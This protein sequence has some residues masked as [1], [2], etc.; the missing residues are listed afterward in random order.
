MGFQICRFS[1]Q[2]NQTRWGHISGD[3]PH[4]PNDHL[5][6]Q[7]LET[8]VI[9]TADLIALADRTGE[10]PLSS[11]SSRVKAAQLISPVTTDATIVCQGLNY[12]DHAAESGH[13]ERKENLFFKKASSAICGPYDT[14]VRPQ[15]VELLDYEIEIGVVLRKAIS[16]NTVI[17]ETNCGDYIAGFV[18]ANDVSARDVMFGAGYFQWFKG[19]SYR[20]FCPVGPILYLLK[21][22]EVQPIL[23]SLSIQLKLN[24]DIRQSA[25][26]DTQIYKA[27][28]T[29]DLLGD[30]MDMKPGDL[31]LTGTPGGVIAQGTPAILKILTDNLVNDT[32]R[33]K[34]YVE[35]AS[36][37]AEFLKPGDELELTLTDTFNNISLGGQLSVIIEA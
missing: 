19:K 9:S 26:S 11:T 35:E 25:S 27:P 8:S 4:R 16:A 10:L 23:N 34:E 5:T 20:T 7:M 14:I 1:D 13:Q 15:G 32:K 30:F 37:N 28:E 24:N 17:D 12:S 31:L 6:I 29:L 3:A 22:D 18:L 2:N 33:R 36:R 21:P